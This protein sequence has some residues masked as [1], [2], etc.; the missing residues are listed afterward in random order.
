MAE[1]KKRKSETGLSSAR[2]KAIAIAYKTRS[3]FPYASYGRAYLQRGDPNSWGYGTFGP[4][5]K[6]A[7][8][9]QRLNRKAFGYIGKGSYMKRFGRSAQRVL[10]RARAGQMIADHAGVG[11]EYRMARKLTGHGLYTGSGE[12]EQQGSNDLV[13]GGGKMG[14]VPEFSS[15]RD[16]SG[17]LTVTH[18]EY[19]SDIYGNDLL[20]GSSTQTLPFVNRAF[21]LNPGIEETFPWLSQV[22]QNFEE[23][24]FTQLMFTYKSIIA[25]V[26]SSNG[27]VGTV[28]M[29]TNYNASKP[30]F[31]N[32][33]E[34]MEY[35]HASSRKTT[36]DMLHGIECDPTKISGD[37]GHY[38]RSQGLPSNQ[39][40]KTYDWGKFQIAIANPP[41]SFA[42]ASIGEL[43]VSYTVRLRK[44]K[45]FVSR[46]L[47]ITRSVFSTRN[48][49]ASPWIP[50]LSATAASGTLFNTTGQLMKE[51]LWLTGQSNG[52]P[53]EFGFPITSGVGTTSGVAPDPLNLQ[54]QVVFPAW[55]AGNVEI[56]LRVSGA[57]MPIV[58]GGAAEYQLGLSG[59]L[60]LIEDMY[61]LNGF[62][63]LTAG[64]SYG[65][66]S[67]T[68][69]N[70]DLIVHLEVNQ[71][72]NNV[73]NVLV[74]TDVA[75]WNGVSTSTYPYSIRS[76]TFD[77]C[78]Y[79]QSFGTTANPAP[80]LVSSN[81]SVVPYNI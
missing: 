68:T 10:K 20:P 32:K 38:T 28:I 15:A 22:A 64:S 26:S 5:Y 39:D 70:K 75:D 54:M 40:I 47:G 49:T 63:G 59:N 19:V 80:V 11:S 35:V 81:G 8:E 14:S 74:I 50:R 4:S 53:I 46:G 67:C 17:A 23:Y 12:Y 69:Q 36:E 65:I 78:E 41:A 24:E 43:W 66:A 73:D 71:A 3:A 7:T 60:T 18:R 76:M 37:P 31:S 29:T 55:Y 56:K 1:V 16:E 27:Q 58:G 30:E 42:N 62:A 61:S 44:P 34:M 51:S 48:L 52:L 33:A 77:L 79:N 57:D 6:E 13:T 21:A 25:D 2:R 9:E 45:F 72:S